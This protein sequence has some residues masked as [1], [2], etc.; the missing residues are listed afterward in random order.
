MRAHRESAQPPGA[1]HRLA[2]E[3]RGRDRH[4]EAG[5]AAEQRAKGHLAL[6]PG[7]SGAWAAVHA[8]D[9]DSEIAI[10]VRD[11]RIAAM[12][13]GP[14]AGYALAAQRALP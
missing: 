5:E 10:R 7:Q 14:G 3:L 8:V 9:D 12:A 6:Q 2:P 13:D 11:G 1:G 4:R